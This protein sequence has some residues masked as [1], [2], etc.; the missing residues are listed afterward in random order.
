[1]ERARSLGAAGWA[2]DDA[3]RPQRLRPMD[4]LRA[5]TARPPTGWMKLP[6]CQPLVDA[7]ASEWSTGGW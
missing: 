7:L 6:S 1:M 2:G 4:A 5:G 3:G